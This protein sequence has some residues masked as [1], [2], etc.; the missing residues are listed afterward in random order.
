MHAALLAIMPAVVLLLPTPADVNV[1]QDMRIKVA[2]ALHVQWANTKALSA[3]PPHA[4]RVLQA[5]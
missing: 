1:L 3:V 4:R 2:P 5:M